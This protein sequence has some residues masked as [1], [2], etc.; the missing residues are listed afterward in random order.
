[1]IT[2]LRRFVFGTQSGRVPVP[3]TQPAVLHWPSM[4]TLAVLVVGLGSIVSVG[5]NGPDGVVLQKPLQGEWSN[6]HN[7][8]DQ[9]SMDAR[10]SPENQPAEK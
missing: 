9:V 6:F 4:R 3:Q 7:D 5:C 10:K 1:M 2:N 8:K